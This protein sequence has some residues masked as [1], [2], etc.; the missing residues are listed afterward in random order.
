[1]RF[2]MIAAV[3]A[4]AGMAVSNS[5]HADI[6][7]YNDTVWE[8]GHGN[9]ANTTLYAGAGLGD[10]TTSGLLKDFSTG[11]FTTITATLTAVNVT[12]SIFG[13]PNVGTPA[14]NVFSGSAELNSSASYA[15]TT[16]DWSYSVT[17]TGLNPSKTYE[18]VTTIDRGDAAYDFDQGAASRWGKF[19]ISGADSFTNASSVSDGVMDLGGGSS[20][21]LNAY[22]TVRGDIIQWTGITA[23]DGSFTVVSEN[24]GGDGSLYEP[25]KAYGMQAFRLTEIESVSSGSTTVPEPGSLTLLSLGSLGMAWGVRRRRGRGTQAAA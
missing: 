7:M 18:F 14:N 16:L 23:A 1:M 5:V 20:L 22:N 11:S 9:P 10:G 15:S 6:V 25:I 4:V 19:S 8:S 17:F 12:D 24:P 13:L 2:P 3:V 21:L